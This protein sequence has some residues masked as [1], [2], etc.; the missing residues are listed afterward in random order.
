MKGLKPLRVFF[1]FIIPGLKAG[2]FFHLVC[3]ANHEL[4]RWEDRGIYPARLPPKHEVRRREDR[5]IY[6][7][8]FPRR[9]TK[10]VAGQAWAIAGF[11][12]DS[13]PQNYRNETAVHVRADNYPPLHALGRISIRPNKLRRFV[14][15]RCTCLSGAHRRGQGEFQLVTPF[16]S[17]NTKS[18]LAP[19]RVSAF[20][21]GA[22][23]KDQTS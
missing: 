13:I 22:K 6:P 2:A 12:E 16:D 5:D 11:L 15:A 10:C 21:R 23:K 8:C 9:S 19:L 3:P 1:S 14:V 18:V 20:F 4:R 7:A 17:A